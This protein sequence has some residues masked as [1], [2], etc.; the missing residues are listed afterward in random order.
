MTSK[1]YH[2]ERDLHYNERIRVVVQG[3]QFVR[4]IKR[5]SDV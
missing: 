3:E 2:I 1:I 4:Y 5:W